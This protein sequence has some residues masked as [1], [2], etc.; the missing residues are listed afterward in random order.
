MSIQDVED[1][2]R[3]VTQQNRGLIS[4]RGVNDSYQVEGVYGGVTYAMGIS[5][6]RIGQFYPH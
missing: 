6:G 3:S 5:N 2:I 1:A 4:S